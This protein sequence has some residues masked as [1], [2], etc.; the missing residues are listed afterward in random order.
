MYYTIK[1]FEK[2]R[3]KIV[4]GVYLVNLDTAGYERNG[5]IK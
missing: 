4:T 2:K 5:L 1:H 3:M